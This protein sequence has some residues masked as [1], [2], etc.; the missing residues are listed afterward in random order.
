VLVELA[1]N[2]AAA[3]LGP[4]DK[5]FMPVVNG[6][7]NFT[8]LSVDRPGSE[9][10]LAFWLYAYDWRTELYTRTAIRTYSEFFDVWPGE[11]AA[12]R[13]LQGFQD[14]PRWAGGQPF[15]VPPIVQ[16]VVSGGVG[17]FRF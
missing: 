4:A 2:P 6:V 9:F 10:R 13:L 7:V 11:P 15:T 14:A 3:Q 5:A 12:L 17:P 8:L 1:N 16:L